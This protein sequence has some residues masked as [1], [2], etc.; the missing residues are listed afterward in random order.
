MKKN[1]IIFLIIGIICLTVVFFAVQRETT[2]EYLRIHVRANSN[3]QVDQ[4][5]KYEIKDNLVTFLTPF[6]AEVSSKSEAISLLNDKK[7]Q[8]EDICNAYLNQQGFSYGAKVEIKSEYFPSRVYED[9]TLKA[10]VYDAIIVSLGEAKGDN[11]WCVVYPPLCFVKSAPIKYR[12]K[13]L[14]IIEKFK[15]REGK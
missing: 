4:D 7:E 3:L 6:I 9:T 10:G 14:K 13:I 11:W 2:T 1:G 8:M 15:Q 5:V 12:S